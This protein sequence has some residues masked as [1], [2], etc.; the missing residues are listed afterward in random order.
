MLSIEK[1]TAGY[2]KNNNVIKDITFDVQRGEICVILGRNGAGKSTLLKSV[3]GLLKPTGSI[4]IDGEEMVGVNEKVRAKNIAYVAQNVDLPNLTVYETI[5]LSRLPYYSLNPT[6]K[7]KEVVW[8]VI[9][10]FGLEDKALTLSKN[11]SGGEQQLVAIARSMAQEPKVLVFDEPTSNLDVAN[12]MLLE[13]RIQSIAK[14]RGITVLISMH[15][16]STAY[17][18][19]DKFVFI[20]DG[21]VLAQ[22]TKEIFTEENVYRTLDRKCK[23]QTIDGTTFIKFEKE[24]L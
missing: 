6:K 12:E 4:T 10:E 1:L 5:M 11:L 15:D 18:L 21:E 23:I 8:N 16:L 9:Q 13:N 22:G 19:G 17:D 3:L 20:K 14:E 7:D 2:S 24:T